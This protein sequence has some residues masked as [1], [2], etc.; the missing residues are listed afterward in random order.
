MKKTN[1]YPSLTK[2]DLARAYGVN[3]R[4]FNKWLAPH[5]KKIGKPFGRLYTPQ[6]VKLIMGLIGEV[7]LSA[8]KK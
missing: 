1:Y 2:T 6:Q 7:D 8:F 3:I 5:H 4:T